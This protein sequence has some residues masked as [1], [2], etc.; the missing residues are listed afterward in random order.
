VDSP[1]WTPSASPHAARDGRRVEPCGEPGLRPAEPTAVRPVHELEAVDGAG[2]RVE[3]E[4]G[5]FDHDVAEPVTEVEQHDRLVVGLERP[6]VERAPLSGDD[7][8]VGAVVLKVHRVPA[9][10]RLLPVVR[11]RRG[12]EPVVR[13]PVVPRGAGHHVHGAVVVDAHAVGVGVG[14]ALDAVVVVVVAGEVVEAE[15]PGR[16][17]AAV[18]AHVDQTERVLRARVDPRDLG[19]EPAGPDERVDQRQRIVGFDRSFGGV[20]LT[21]T[22][23]EQDERRETHGSAPLL[24]VSQDP[25]HARGAFDRPGGAR[26]RRR[27]GGCALVPRRDPA[28]ARDEVV[29]RDVGFVLVDERVRDAEQVPQPDLRRAMR[30][31]RRALSDVEGLRVEVGPARR[32]AD[33]VEVGHETLR[34]VI[35]ARPASPRRRPVMPQAPWETHAPLDDRLRAR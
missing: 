11:E 34:A 25:E 13:V 18:R 33:V 17:V 28:A 9:G 26:W 27:H 20:D 19:G 3:R 30:T 6:G 16:R 23:D 32:T 22:G 31:P 5:L 10:R 1:G 2:V 15:V 12:A 21:V 35:V 7:L 8:D 14:E 4:R 24:Q 29:D